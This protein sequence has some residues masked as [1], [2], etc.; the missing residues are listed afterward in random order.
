MSTAYFQIPVSIQSDPDATARL[1]PPRALTNLDLHY[2]RVDER[3]LKAI[4]RMSAPKE[5]LQEVVE[6]QRNQELTQ[7]QVASALNDY[8]PPRL[9]TKY[10]VL[11][12][13]RAADEGNGEAQVIDPFVLDDQG[14]RI[15]DTFQIVRSG[16]YLIDV[17]V[18][19]DKT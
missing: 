12:Q 14:N 8:P 9:K 15:T 7:E 17:P 5:R 2:I 11:A 18:A 10:R 13:L 3:R 19:L 1:A 4:V 16:F 6:D